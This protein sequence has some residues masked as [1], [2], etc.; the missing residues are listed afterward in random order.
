MPWRTVV[1]LAV[2]ALAL[3]SLFGSAE[4]TTVAFAEEHGVPGLT[5]R[6]AGLLGAR[7]LLAGVIT[8][9][10]HWTKARSPPAQ[11]GTAPDPAAWPRSALSTG[12]ADGGRL[13]VAG[14]AIA[15]G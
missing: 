1:P 10:M 4:V 5:G 15:P 9:A 13:F 2:V 6:A 12:L 7:S 11:G 14:F 3:G 8:G